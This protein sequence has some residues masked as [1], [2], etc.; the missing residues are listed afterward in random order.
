VAYA[1]EVRETITG[2]RRNIHRNKRKGK[3]WKRQDFNATG[4]RTDKAN[5]PL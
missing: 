1:D 3:E 5:L 2:M 4:E